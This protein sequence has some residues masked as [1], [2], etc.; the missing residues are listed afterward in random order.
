VSWLQKNAFLSSDGRQLCIGQVQ[1][2]SSNY[3][4]SSKCW[5]RRNYESCL[6][7]SRRLVQS[8]WRQVSNF[9]LADS[10][11]VVWENRPETQPT[12]NGD[13]KEATAFWTRMPNVRRQETKDTALWVDGRQEQER[14]P[15]R[16]VDRR[17]CGVVWWKSAGTEPLST[18][19]KQLAEVGKAGIERQ[20]ALSPWLVI[21]MMTTLM[22]RR[23]VAAQLRFGRS[24]AD[25]VRFTNSFTYLLCTP[26]NGGFWSGT[27]DLGSN[28]WGCKY[29]GRELTGGTLT[30][31]QMLYL[32]QNRC[33][34]RHVNWTA[35]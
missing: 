28:D 26:R 22:L 27:F 13:W 9:H 20:R 4:Q 6:F 17:Y 16:R 15:T 14:P 29:R 25:I 32:S 33:M 31:G 12:A 30:E 24:I 18:G 34:P 19:P 23:R 1:H 8:R 7:T 5:C 3:G 35:T 2:Q 10:H 11:A 21:M